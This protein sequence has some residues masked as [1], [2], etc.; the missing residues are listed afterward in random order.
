MAD[1]NDINNQ[2]DDQSMFDSSVFEQQ[3]R[4]E[5]FIDIADLDLVPEVDNNDVK[6]DRQN[7]QVNSEKK[8]NLKDDAEL[9]DEIFATGITDN[10]SIFK[11]IE[12]PVGEQIDDIF[13]V[14]FNNA[15]S[16]LLSKI[17]T[18]A[19]ISGDSRYYIIESINNLDIELPSTKQGLIFTVRAIKG[20]TQHKLLPVHGA[21]FNGQ[22]NYFMLPSNISVTFVSDPETNTWFTF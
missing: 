11:S 19:K 8:H 14:K 21:S 10:K 4:K 5:S 12:L 2:E 7:D 15:S 17:T 3:Q 20:N 1:L 13:G 9:L 6:F 22:I 18:N 16:S